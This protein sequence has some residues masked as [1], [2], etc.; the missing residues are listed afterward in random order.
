MQIEVQ[1]LTLTT[2]RVEAPEFCPSETCG[3]RINWSSDPKT[4]ERR[5]CVWLLEAGIYAVRRMAWTSWAGGIESKPGDLQD[6]D[7]SIT[8]TLGYSCG[9]CGTMLVPLEMTGATA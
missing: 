6:Y 7:Q 4:D 2:R 1:A 8:G 3:K 5:P 9:E